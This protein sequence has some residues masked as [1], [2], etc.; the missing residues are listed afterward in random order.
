MA[1]GHAVNGTRQIVRVPDLSWDGLVASAARKLGRARVHP[2]L[3]KGD[4]YRGERGRTYEAL[5]WKP[6]TVIHGAEI[7]ALFKDLGFQG[8]LAAFVAWVMSSDIAASCERCI[9]IT[10]DQSHFSLRG[11]DDLSPCL[12][13]GYR[14]SGYGCTL[15]LSRV[16]K[17]MHT[18]WTFVAFRDVEAPQPG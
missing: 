1:D 4:L 10:D 8:N 11:I 16:L 5:V 2:L 7:R 12:L 14:G 13:R 3:L 9:T 17:P 6:E 18:H 15:T